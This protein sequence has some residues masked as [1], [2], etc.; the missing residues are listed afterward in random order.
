[1]CI[2]VYETKSTY[3]IY[4]SIHILV[5][6]NIY[7]YIYKMFY[8]YIL[9]LCICCCYERPLLVV[10]RSSTVLFVMGRA[11]AQAPELAGGRGSCEDYATPMP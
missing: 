11:L 4:S 7:I 1:M 9:T 3:T 8:I 6:F 5:I 10:P 2:Y